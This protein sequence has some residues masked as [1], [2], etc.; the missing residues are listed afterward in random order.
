ME[1]F[2]L[3]QVA[4]VK[5]KPSSAPPIQIHTRFLFNC[6]TYGLIRNFS[7]LLQKYDLRARTDKVF[8]DSHI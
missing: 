1:L 7:F 5:R 3:P 2:W 8:I 4:K 6:E